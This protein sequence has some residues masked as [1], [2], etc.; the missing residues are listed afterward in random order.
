MSD[1]FLEGLFWSLIVLE[2][3]L[4]SV[5]L[6]AGIGWLVK[7]LDE[8]VDAIIEEWADHE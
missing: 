5:L 3:L 1:A 8:K 2:A 6:I 7:K 4:G